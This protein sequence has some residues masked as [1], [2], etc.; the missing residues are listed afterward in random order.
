[1]AEITPFFA[2]FHQITSAQHPRERLSSS[3]GLTMGWR[4]VALSAK[5]GL[6]HF[7]ELYD[8]NPLRCR[9]LRAGWT[10]RLNHHSRTPGI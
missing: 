4:R 5:E 7:T 8:R 9:S 1:M 2:L 6:H 3:T 10:R